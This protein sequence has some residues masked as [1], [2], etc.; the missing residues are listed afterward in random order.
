MKV[1]EKELTP[2]VPSRHNFNR[3]AGETPEMIRQVE[4][5][6]GKSRSSRGGASGSDKT[7]EVRTGREKRERGRNVHATSVGGTTGDGMAKW[8]NQ[9][10]NQQSQK[11]FRHKCRTHKYRKNNDAEGEKEIKL[12]KGMR[13]GRRE[14]IE[15]KCRSIINLGQPSSSRK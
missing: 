6:N 11:R 13:G 7:V 8:N 1:P 12:I 15:K 10:K 9:R 14:A 4:K 5:E 3:N 2:A